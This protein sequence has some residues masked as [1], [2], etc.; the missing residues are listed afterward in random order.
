MKIEIEI[1]K[2]FEKHYLNDKFED[3]LNRVLFDLKGYIG[4]WVCGLY[5]YETVEMLIKAFKESDV[6]K[7]INVPSKW[8]PVTERL[9]EK[10]DKYLVSGKWGSGYK[11]VDTAEFDIEDGYFD[12][13][14]NFT[15]E[16]WQPLP[17]PYYSMGEDY[18]FVSKE[19]ADMWMNAKP[20]GKEKI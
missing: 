3:S 18:G 12:C 20:V 8:I 19:E 17:K 13:C 16:A 9:P 14:W 5:E 15:V 7:D 10:T 1:P 4:S 6:G 11:V 2:E